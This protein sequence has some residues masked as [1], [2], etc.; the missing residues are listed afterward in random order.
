MNRRLYPT[1]ILSLPSSH[2]HPLT[3]ILP[4]NTSS[5]PVFHHIQTPNPHFQHAI[6]PPTPPSYFQ[7]RYPRCRMRRPGFGKTLNL[8]SPTGQTDAMAVRSHSFS[9]NRAKSSSV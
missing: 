4:I 8:N 3:P 2:S 5:P 9:P 6:L 1:H 7:P